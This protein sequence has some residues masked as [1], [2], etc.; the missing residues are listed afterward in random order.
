M[1]LAVTAVLTVGILVMSAIAYVGV[2][3]RL[4]GDLDRALLQ[5]A[6]A[7]AAAIA[8][9]PLNKEQDLV[10][11]SRAY[12]AARTGAGSGPRAILLVR[13]GS[14]KVLSNSEVPIERAAGSR[15]ALDPRFARRAFLDFT[16]AKTAYRVATVPIAGANG[17]V[18]AVFEAALSESPDRVVVSQLGWTLGAAGLAV[19][20]FGA[21]LSAWVARASLAPV[22]R[23]AA[24]AE[25][26]TQS[27]L[28][29]RVA[30][31]G[32][33]DEVGA[34]VGSLNAMLD[35]LETA[36]TE[37][38]RFIADASHELRTPLAV[39]KGHLEVARDARLT[40]EEQADLA[41]IV[42]DEVDRMT[43]LV[44]DLLVLARLE[45][46][47]VRPHQELELST[48]LEEAVARA[49]SLGRTPIEQRC[50]GPLWVS[51]DP[52]QL[53]QALLNLL[54]NA[55]AHT[56]EDGVV[57]AL[58]YAQGEAA[59]V[60]IADSGPGIRPEEID[61]IFDRFYRAQGPRPSPSS[62]SGLGLAITKRLVQL[63]RGTIRAANR[64]EGGA[65]FTVSLPRIAAPAKTPPTDAEAQ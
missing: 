61:R 25:R 19:V 41:A 12:L 51:G 34:M 54:A 15:T 37:Q 14:G 63:H 46:G 6:D 22:R 23:A 17:R 58:C 4:S 31:D 26:I 30:Y 21:A 39:I 44:D 5:E 57:T 52:D 32:A 56:P 48:V 18:V 29:G 7:Y 55:V 47:R 53:M 27:S 8:K 20:V 11:V 13:F 49:R 3:R 28:G 9:T 1:A 62:G 35:R 64:P 33:A 50:E 43:R 16:L 10:A 65:V 24:T 2:S 60:G 42:T 38:R 45:S 40:D 36:F 59:L